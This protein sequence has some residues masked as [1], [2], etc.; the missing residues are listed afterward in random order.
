MLADGA[1]GHGGG[2]VAARIAVAAV[3]E[4]FARAPESSPE[5]IAELIDLANL[6]VVREQS[7]Q[8][9]LATM[10]ATF[11]I[12][13][14]D[15]RTGQMCWGHIGDSRLYFIRAG[16]VVARTKDHSL[17]QSMIDAG[18]AQPEVD[19]M[20]RDADS[21]VLVASLGSLE[22]FTP[23]IVTGAYAIQPGD[24]WLLC[25][26]GLW[27][28]FRE[29]D[30]IAMLDASATPNEWLYRMEQR[31]VAADRPRQDNFSAL[32]VWSASGR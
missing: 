11:V 3:L 18:Y 30:L 31:I 16:R 12:A 1:G 26:D 20:A 32:A 13:T 2:D 8:P 23:D 14:F 29:S 4:A 24:A 19:G 5:R 9:D 10:R 28:H 25:S 21:T 17:M 15:P 22:D 6:A 7:A 27:E